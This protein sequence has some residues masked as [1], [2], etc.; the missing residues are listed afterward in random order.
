MD[1]LE[2]TKNDLEGLDTETLKGMLG[3]CLDL[4]SQFLTAQMTK[5]ILINGLYG[6]HINEGFLFFNEKMAQSITGLGRFF[7]KLSSKNIEAKLQSILPADNPYVIYND[8]DSC[9]YQI[10]NIMD[11]IITK[12]PDKGINDYVDMAIKFEERIVDP[13]I[14]ESITEFATK[15][16][17]FDPKAVGA[18]REIV[19]D[20]VMFVSKKHY[21]ARVRDAEGV[22]YPADNPHMKIMG[23]EYARRSTP[24]WCKEKLEESL[25]IILD[26]T[27]PELRDWMNSIR[28]EFARQP[29]NRICVYGSTSRVDYKLTDKNIPWMCKASIYY[30]AYI[31]NHNLEAKYNLIG[32]DSSIKIVYL[33]SPNPFGTNCLAYIS[34]NFESEFKEYLDLD[35]LFKKGFLD[36]LNNMVKVINYDILSKTNILEDW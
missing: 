7:I 23:L 18:K 33:V 34:D 19:A 24:D 4:Q 2:Y 6:A 30:N 1:L 12:N 27:E 22:R 21:V 25:N 10:G 9:Y 31:K 20:R 14:Q 28:D 32:N 13:V 16:N 8:T 26:K 29:V 17:S 36:P 35:A 3:E 15:M 11:Q 5:K